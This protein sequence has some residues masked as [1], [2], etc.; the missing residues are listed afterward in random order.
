VKIRAGAFGLGNANAADEVTSAPPSRAAVVD[1]AAGH[2]AAGNPLTAI[3]VIVD[4]FLPGWFFS[5]RFVPGGQESFLSCEGTV[6][7]VDDFTVRHSRD[8]R[9]DSETRPRNAGVGIVDNRVASLARYPHLIDYGASRLLQAHFASSS[10]P[11]IWP[12]NVA[13][14]QEARKFA[15]HPPYPWPRVARH[16]RSERSVLIAR[17]PPADRRDSS[18]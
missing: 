17:G 9:S 2:V 11:R 7:H 5:D 16:L 14:E 4:L 18:A 10:T 1:D 12:R 8:V 13:A 15:Q 3:F 6:E